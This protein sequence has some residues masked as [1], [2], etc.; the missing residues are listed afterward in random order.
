MN[1]TTYG[2]TSQCECPCC[3]EVIRNLWD[4][5]I[6]E[7]KTIECPHCNGE[8]TMHLSYDISLTSY[9]PNKES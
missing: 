4:Y 5:S 3:G 9:E 7:D 8:V 2:D 1:K 6:E